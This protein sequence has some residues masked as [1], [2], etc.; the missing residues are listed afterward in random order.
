MYRFRSQYHY[1]FLALLAV[2]LLVPLSQAAAQTGTPAPTSPESCLRMETF[3]VPAGHSP[4]DVAPAADGERVWYTAQGAAALGLLDPSTGAVETIPLGDGSSPHGVIVGPDGAAWITDSGLNAIVRV[5]GETFAVETW[6]IASGNANLNTAVFDHQGVLWFTGQGGVVGRLDPAS[7]PAGTSLET[8]AAPR[9]RG[10]YGIAATPGGEIWFASLAGNY[11]G[12]VVHGDGTAFTLE[13]IEPPTPA[14]GT[15]RVW[16]DSAGVLWTSEWEAGQ[17]GRYDPDSGAWLEWRLP[18]DGP[19]AY[20]VYVDENDDIWLSDFAANSLVR[21][22]PDTEAF[23][24]L[25][26]PDAGASVRQI[27]GRPGEVWGA[28]SSADKL[29]VVF[30]S[31][32]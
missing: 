6:P 24:S 11:L 22:D 32:P 5:D 4:H 25:P 30:T 10:P 23:V 26:L 19:Q 9:G 2:S 31:C 16:S 21:F 3:A 28:E 1:S 7:Q 14:Q 29:V 12:R 15:R 8:V 20:A 18:G 17:V 13:V 27:H